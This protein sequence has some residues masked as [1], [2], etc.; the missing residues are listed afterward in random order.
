MDLGAY[1]N[2]GD[3]SIVAEKNGINISRLRGYRLMKNEYEPIIFD[4]DTIHYIEKE[5]IERMVCGIPRF[6]I[7]PIMV[8][9]SLDKENYASKYYD[10]KN[11]K[12]K[13]DKIHG[14][15]RKNLKYVLKRDMKKVKDNFDVFNKYIK[16]DDVLY[17]HAKLGSNN[18]SGKTHLYYKNE[19]WYLDSVDDA[20][21][22]VYCDI[23]AKID[24]DTLKYIKENTGEEDTKDNEES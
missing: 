6:T 8:T 21:D 12:I 24:P 17:I 9:Y 1:I 4:D 2:I 10:Y 5:S 7:N 15:F 11:N 13:W 20:Y 19:S 23:Y 3:L 14:K 22:N 18:W 16:R